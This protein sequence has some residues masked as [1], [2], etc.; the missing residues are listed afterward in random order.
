MDRFQI[1]QKYTAGSFKPYAGPSV[2][3]LTG[4]LAKP[5]TINSRLINELSTM[6]EL[7]YQGSNYVIFR[8]DEKTILKIPHCIPGVYEQARVDIV[9]FDHDGYPDV[10][11]YNRLFEDTRLDMFQTM[12][13]FTRTKFI[14][15][16]TVYCHI[17]EYVS[18]GQKHFIF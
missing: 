13:H 15:C 3:L 7:I 6:L 16:D 17:M 11:K 9:D 2:N 8:L 1:R 4:P 18:D 10:D 12:A 14:Y 5:P